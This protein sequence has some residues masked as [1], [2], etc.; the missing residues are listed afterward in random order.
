M[1]GWK[2]ACMLYSSVRVREMEGDLEIHTYRTIEIAFVYT[3]HIL[4]LLT[5]Q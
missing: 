3:V 5:S 2:G 4:H 1:V